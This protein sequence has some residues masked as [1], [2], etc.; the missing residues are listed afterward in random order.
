MPF[1]VETGTASPTATSYSSVADADEHIQANH[2]TSDWVGLSQAEKE[3]K[4]NKASRF[5][6]TLLKWQ[7]VVKDTSQGLLWPRDDFTDKEGRTVASNTIPSVIKEATI[8]FANELVHSRLSAEF[9]KL[10]QESFADTSDTYAAPKRVGGSD[11]VF[12]YQRQLVRLGYG[13]N[14]SVVVKIWRA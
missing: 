11:V 1:E 14:A 8:E 7:S 13:R 12:D 9:D 10:I 5:L 2:P 3:A 4:L 6:D